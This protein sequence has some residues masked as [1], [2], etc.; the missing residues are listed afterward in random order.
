M[1]DADAPLNYFNYFTEVEDT[2][3]RR[4]GAHMLVSPLDWA[5]IESWKE[6]D[7]PLAVVLRGIER[8]FDAFDR[9]PRRHRKVNS[10]F[11]CQQSVE[12][13][14]AEHRQ[15]MVGAAEG[16]EAAVAVQVVGGPDDADSPFQ[17][18]RVE[19]YLER[20][21]G[22]LA[23]ARVRAESRETL[24]EALDRACARLSEIR[25]NA[26]AA[27]RLDAE[28]LERDLTSLD[29]L[30]LTAVRES[31]TPE[32]LDEARAEA[33]TALKAHKK[34]MDK[35]FYAQTFE[36]F[37]SRRLRESAGIPRLSLFFMD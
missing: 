37:V 21:T 11:Y 32:A 1:M 22:D 34:G 15:S 29:T 10:I 17:R 12:E 14:F 18:E 28:A 13:C 23:S 27:Q 31:A 35:A 7:I 20:I 9:Q 6:M 24:S 26:E 25:A 4:R 30:V 2:F 8:A 36:N 33:K 3:V 5:L 19:R 16:V